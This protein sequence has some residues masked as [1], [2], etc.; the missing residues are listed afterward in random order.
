MKKV[1][2]GKMY[3]TE[4]AKQVGFWSNGYSYRE[5]GWVEETL[6]QKKTGEF[7]LEGEGGANSRYSREVERNWYGS[8]HYLIPFTKDEAKD[9]VERHCTGEEYEEIFGE[10]EE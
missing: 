4:T 7:F 10:V 3:N 6:Y 5:F 2:N 1:I 8:G 9:W